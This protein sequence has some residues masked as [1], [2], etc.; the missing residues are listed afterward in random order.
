MLLLAC[1]TLGL[2]LGLT[3]PA[4][5]ETTLETDDDKILYTL[6]LAVSRNIASFNFT[7]AELEKIT[8]GLIDGAMGRD[9]QVDPEVYG[10]RID[11][12]IQA[13]VAKLAE[14]EQKVGEEFLAKAATEEGAEKT[15]TG[16][17]YL[18]LS[19]GDGATPGP[20]DSVKLNYRGTLADGSEFD[21]SKGDPVTFSVG[22]VI[23]CFGDAVQKMKV[24]GKSKV[25][26]S[27]DLA[28]GERGS[29][30]KIRPGAALQFEIELLEVIP[31]AGAPTP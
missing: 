15:A 30:P 26:C 29:P 7:E 2:A 1:W 6:G 10:P 8:A 13:R 31:A 16:M 18:Q 12:M 17:I 11:P 20:A 23:P 9:P 25:T 5:A 28:Y 3:A 27:S 19:A 21:S 4:L 24:G 22:G 14:Q